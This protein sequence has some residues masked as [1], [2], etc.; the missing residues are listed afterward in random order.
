MLWATVVDENVLWRRFDKP[1]E[2]RAYG[3]K[4]QVLAQWVAPHHL[5]FFKTW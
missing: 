2:F 3:D 5:T 1:R 4:R